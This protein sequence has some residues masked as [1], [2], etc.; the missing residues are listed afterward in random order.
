[1]DDTLKLACT[2]LAILVSVV[3]AKFLFKKKQEPAMSATEFEPFELSKIY[4]VSHDT[5]R[6]T[7]KLATPETPLGLPVGQHISFRFTDTDGKG[8]QRSYTPITGDETLGSVTFM[9]KIYK[10][11][12][13]PKFP[14]GGK[15]SQHLDSLKVGDSVDLRGPKGKLLV[16]PYMYLESSPNL[17]PV[18]TL[19]YSLYI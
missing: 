13:H 1:M 6:F 3:A 7:F 18:H 15:M 11:G 12:V 5:K 8:V 10:A 19:E 14:D 4:Q 9:I 16:H 2:I 17:S